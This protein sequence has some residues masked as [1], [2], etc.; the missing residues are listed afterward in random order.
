M[1]A[2]E[3]K[4]S[5]WRT[6]TSYISTVI[7]IA[8][9]IYV[10]GL[11]GLVLMKG[12]ILGDSFKEKFAFEIYLKEGVRD[13]E[14]MQ[15]KK[16][17][18]AEDFVKETVWKD[19]EKAL[20]EYLKEVDPGENFSMSLGANPLPQ[21][22]DVYFTASFN[23]PDSIQGLKNQ[24]QKNAIVDDLRYPRDL[25]FV[26]YENINKISFALLIVGGLLSIIAIGLI[27][28]TI[29]L[30]VYSKR[31]ILK[32][33]QLV[34]ASNWF[35]KRPFIWHGIVLG[36][37][38]GVIA[39]FALAGTLKIIYDFWPAFQEELQ[40]VTLDLALYGAMLIIAICISWFATQF[41]VGRYLRLKTEKLYY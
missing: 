18:D 26:V 36:F 21:N 31:F 9:V 12:K 22:I 10:V 39:V 19:K 23:H 32:T 6:T 13:I 25:L 28:N 8:M 27:T 35:I 38:S 30:R 11:L 16:E 17:L 14:I 40:N 29:R 34:G 2:S 41:A 7:S 4:Y 33:M 3:G 37:F 15:L 1:S 24:L 5:N 20:A